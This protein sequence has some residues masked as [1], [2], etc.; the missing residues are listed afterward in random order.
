MQKDPPKIKD[1]VIFDLRTIKTVFWIFSDIG[2]L[3]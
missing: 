3:I 1:F 2:L